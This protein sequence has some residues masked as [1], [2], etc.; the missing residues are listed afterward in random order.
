[1]GYHA[2]GPKGAEGPHPLCTVPTLTT[3]RMVSPRT[4]GDLLYPHCLRQGSLEVRKAREGVIPA[5]SQGPG[6]EMQAGVVI[7]LH[8][9]AAQRPLHRRW[10]LW[11]LPSRPPAPASAPSVAGQSIG[12]SPSANK[13]A[14]SGPRLGEPPGPPCSWAP[15]GV[16]LAKGWEMVD[17]GWVRRVV[18]PRPRIWC[19][20]PPHALSLGKLQE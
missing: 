9:G 2:H 6:A 11:E 7:A 3:R 18:Q 19:P 12:H 17:T 1:M 16:E 4:S 14:T 13:R 15:A 10:A 20:H 5:G 8:A